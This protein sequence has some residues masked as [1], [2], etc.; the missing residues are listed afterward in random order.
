MRNALQQI[1]IRP[2]HMLQ[3]WRKTITQKALPQYETHQGRSPKGTS[4]HPLG[5]VVESA[6]RHGSHPEHGA[7][8]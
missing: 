5:G 8:L 1:H 6:R 4:K 7:A 2:A 3:P